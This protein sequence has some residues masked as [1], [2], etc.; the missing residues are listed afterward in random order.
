M[1]HICSAIQVVKFY[2]SDTFVLPLPSHHKFPMAKYRMLRDRIAESTLVETCQLL[3]APQATV[4][5]LE[6]AHS[7]EYVRRVLAG[8]LSDIEQRRIGFPWSLQMVERARRS[9]G[10]SVAAGQSALNDGF[11][12]NLAGGTHHAFAD[13]GQGYC[14]FNDSC[15]AARWLQHL[16]L[17]QTVAIVD[18]DVHQ[19]NG[20]AAIT[21]DEPTIFTFS[22]HCCDNFPFRKTQSNLDIELPAGTTDELYL[23]ELQRGLDEAFKQFRPDIVF[24][25]SGADAFADDRFGKLKLSKPG[26]RIRD[27]IVFEYFAKRDVSVAAS[28][29]GGYARNL[30]DLVDIHFATVSAGVDTFEASGRNKRTDKKVTGTFQVPSSSDSDSV[31]MISKKC[32]N[33]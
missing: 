20:T 2:Y 22:I 18:L 1:Y 5:Q 19:G 12:A 16:G 15:V 27:E 33:G 30:D 23:R 9:V 17:V 24:Y 28:M 11:S 26:L 4:Q 7:H 32:L 29:A 6:L 31:G 25:V 21:A 10:A 8:E 3:I 13:S 14:V